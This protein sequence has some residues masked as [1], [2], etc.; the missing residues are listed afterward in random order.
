MS[1]LVVTDHL[2]HLVVGCLDCGVLELEQGQEL[3]QEQ[4]QEQEPGLVVEPVEPVVEHN[5]DLV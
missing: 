2:D 4:E 3:E 5:L 1:L